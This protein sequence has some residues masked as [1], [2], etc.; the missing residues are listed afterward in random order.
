MPAVVLRGTTIDLP[1]VGKYVD[2]IFSMF[3]RLH[4]REEFAGTGIGLAVCRRIV[5]RHKG[6]ITAQSVP[7]QG[8]T[9]TVT[10]PIRQPERDRTE[11]TK[12]AD[13]LRS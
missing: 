10:L 11:W 5:E 2:R 9:F 8:A 13:L 12:T 7:G 4:G 6:T 1:E 3:Q